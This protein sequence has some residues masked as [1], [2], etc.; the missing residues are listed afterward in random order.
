MLGVVIDIIRIGLQQRLQVAANFFWNS[1]SLQIITIIS[2]VVFQ[3]LVSSE[4]FLEKCFKCFAKFVGYF[5]GSVC[6]A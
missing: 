5:A 1:V 4:E 6:S 3:R 2:L